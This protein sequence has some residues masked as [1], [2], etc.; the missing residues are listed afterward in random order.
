MRPASSTQTSLRSIRANARLRGLCLRKLVGQHGLCWVHAERLVHK[1]D[2]FTDA[3][4]A[5][6]RRIRAL[7]WRR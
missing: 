6:Q 2:T 5:T 4:R 7:I 3:Q 1:L